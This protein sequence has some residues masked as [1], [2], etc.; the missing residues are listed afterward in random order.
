MVV[1]PAS[2]AVGHLA[3]HA[4]GVAGWLSL[5]KPADVDHHDDTLVRPTREAVTSTPCKGAWGSVFIAHDQKAPRADEIDPL[6]LARKFQRLAIC[7]CHNLKSRPV[8]A[9]RRATQM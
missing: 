9:G 7:A 5:P 8:F 4:R 2:G 3:I 1:R 6:R